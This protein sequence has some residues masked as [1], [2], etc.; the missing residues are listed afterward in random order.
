MYEEE[1]SNCCGAR[2]TG[3][4]CGECKEHCVSIAEEMEEENAKRS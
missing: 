4:I 3:D 1:N 2:M